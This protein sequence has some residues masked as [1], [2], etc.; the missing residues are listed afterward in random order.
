MF[1]HLQPKAEGCRLR[2]ASRLIVAATVF[3]VALSS[4]A[5]AADTL[6]PKSDITVSDNENPDI[7]STVV[8]AKVNKEI[9]PGTADYGDVIEVHIRGLGRWLASFPDLSS[10]STDTSGMMAVVKVTPSLLL[11][12]EPS[13]DLSPIT[14]ENWKSEVFQTAFHMC[15]YINGVA[16]PE[17]KAYAPYWDPDP[18]VAVDSTGCPDITLRFT[19]AR[20]DT[21]NLPQEQIN[22]I[23]QRWDTLI[24]H[25][26][27]NTSEENWRTGA[28]ADLTVGFDDATYKIHYLSSALNPDY[29][30]PAHPTPEELNATFRVR[31][32]SQF[33]MEWALGIIVGLVLLT[34][35]FGFS[36]NLLRDPTLP[37]RPSLKSNGTSTVQPFSLAFCQIAF[38]T[39]IVVA[40]YLFIYLSTENYNCFNSTALALL[41]ISATTGI[42]AVAI[43]TNAGAA[44][45]NPWSFPMMNFYTKWRG[46]SFFIDLLCERETMSFHRV[47]LIVWTIVLAFVFVRSV[48]NSLGMPTFD[49]TLLILV[50]IINGTYLGMKA[51][52]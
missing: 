11:K 17:I 19:F 49:P 8:S 16:F 25:L 22:D 36:T 33:G 24:H 13:H 2:T 28:K 23:N 7:L 9:N 37:P 1:Q 21:S 40:C 52:Q 12:N 39:I 27:T 5:A 20:P 51:S 30:E 26:Y 15:L 35:I 45:A 38:W 31:P 3:W 50:G 47:Q 32:I 10:T 18:K 48:F 4:S 44:R 29:K 46:F 43:N 42:G 14:V 41:G 34:L 6:T